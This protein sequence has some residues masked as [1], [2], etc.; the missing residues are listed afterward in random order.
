VNNLKKFYSKTCSHPTSYTVG[1]GSEADHSSPSSTK[2]ENDAE[3][4]VP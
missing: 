2:V 4:T 1:T 3:K